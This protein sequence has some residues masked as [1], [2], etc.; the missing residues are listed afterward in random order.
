MTGIIVSFTAAAL[1]LTACPAEPP[2]DE[3]S[4]EDPVT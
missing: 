2:A 1:L 3:E 4:A